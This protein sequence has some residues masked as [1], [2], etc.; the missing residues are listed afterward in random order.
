MSM[1][2][3][4]VEIAGLLFLVALLA[5]GPSASAEAGPFVALEGS[6]SGGGNITT[7]GGLRERLRCR[8]TYQV[9][10]TGD[11]LRLH[12]RCASDSYNFDLTGEVEHRGGAISGSWTEAS[13]KASGTIS[14]RA[15]VDRVEAAAK[16]DTFSANLSLTTRGNRQD[17]TIQSLTGEITNVSITL[18]KG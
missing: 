2:R 3:L 18:D 8:A 11:S 7:S 10:E 16:G 13:R 12:L 14:G 6:W 1:H 17:V 15:S 5:F 9:G 4:R